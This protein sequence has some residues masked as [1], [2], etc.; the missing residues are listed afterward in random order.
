MK[1]I[2]FLL[3]LGLLCGVAGAQEKP[4]LQVLVEKLDEDARFCGISK[5]AIEPIATLTLRNNGIRVV[6]KSNPYLYIHTTAVVLRRG[7]EVLG[8]ALS[9]RVDIRGL[10]ET[11]TSGG[12]KSRRLLP[13]FTQTVLC[14]ADSLISGPPSSIASQHSTALER[15]IKICLGNL[16]Y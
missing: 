15:D 8:C 10:V 7:G 14:E 11:N 13:P 6:P 3:G 4:S 9:S 12:F 5:S 2:T 1:R 16:D